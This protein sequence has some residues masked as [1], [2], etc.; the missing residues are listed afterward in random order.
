MNSGGRASGTEIG[1]QSIKGRALGGG[2]G[3]PREKGGK[4]RSGGSERRRS[5]AAKRRG[6]GR[7]L[8]LASAIGQDL[9]EGASAP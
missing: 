4:E 8:S 5:P 3:W 6:C 2:R 9:A 1:N 7:L